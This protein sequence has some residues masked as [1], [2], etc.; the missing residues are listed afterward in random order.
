MKKRVVQITA[1][2]ALLVLITGALRAGAQGL[3]VNTS[4][5]SANASAMLDV[6]STTKGVLVPRM[7]NAQRNAISSPAT[8]LLIFQ[9]DGTPGFYY[10]DGSAWTAV[11][12]GGSG[13]VTS[14]SAGSL[15]PLFTTSVATGTSTPAITYSLTA[16]AAFS[17]LTNSTNTTGVPVYGKV[18]PAAMFATSGA[19]T[20]SNFYRGDGVWSAVDLSGANVTG[21]LP[22]ANLNSGTGASANTFWQGNGTWSAVDLSTADVTGTL[23]SGNGGTSQSTYTKGD[24]LY[25]SATNT[26]SKLPVGSTGQVLTV[27]SGAPSWATASSG[28]GYVWNAFHA[29]PSVIGTR[30]LAFPGSGISGITT[31]GV[32]NSTPI[33]MA[34]TIDAVYVWAICNLNGGASTIT[35]TLYKNGAATTV[36]GSFTT[37]NTV[38]ATFTANDLTHTVSV[39]AGDLMEVK[40]DQ[41]NGATGDN[42]QIGIGI[43]AH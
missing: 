18:V 17:V 41:T 38:G 9:T 21:N 27:A 5:S 16:A 3:A 1:V 26:L 14:V 35:Y 22:V 39:N 42:V 30:Y 4:G 43:H 11:G 15:S 13:T 24:I 8:G 37:T 7:T 19:A 32:T 34:C 25:A 23:P 12:G 31:A 40:W 29:L 20:S 10:Y 28:G 2:L 36:T 6:T 33:P